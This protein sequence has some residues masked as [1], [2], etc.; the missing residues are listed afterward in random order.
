MKRRSFLK[1]SAAALGSTAV[2]AS[3]LGA[4]S[5]KDAVYELRAYTL[6][7]DK[8]PI[9]DN[10]LSKAYLPALKRMG[11]GPVG[12][13]VE[14]GDQDARKVYVLI[15]HGSADQVVTL[16]ARLAE[17][18]K[19][20]KA[21]GKYLSARASDP[22]YRRIDS[23]LLAPIAGM[24]RLEKPDTSHPR[25]FN[26]RIYESHNE[27]AARKKIEMFDKEELAIFRRVGLTPVF[28]AATVVGSA[29]PNLT[30]MLVF[31]DEAARAAA[32][33]RFRKDAAWKKLSARPEYA[34]KEIISNITN[35]I[36]TPTSYSEI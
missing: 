34:N 26:L 21:A 27:R 17:D 30:Y 24:L 23:S 33:D 22:V 4:E 8:Q 9:L 35:K 13:L 19:Y 31:P 1:A 28:F 15:V 7:A 3:A 6:T 32:W 20:L 14:K 29:M 11:V 18:E 10:Y 2:A 12:V 16:P 36:L 25:L 5:R